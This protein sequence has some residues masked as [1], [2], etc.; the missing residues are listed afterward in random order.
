MLKLVHCCKEAKITQAA[1]AKGLGYS[2]ALISRI[3]RTGELPVDREGFLLSLTGFVDKTPAMEDYLANTLKRA[4]I[5]AL[6]EAEETDDMGEAGQAPGSFLEG[7]F[8]AA[9]TRITFAAG[10]AVIG[11]PQLEQ[12]LCLARLSTFLLKTL[13]DQPMGMDTLGEIEVEVRR[14]L[15]GL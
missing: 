4:D 8:D 3:F 9:E 1:L 12:V 6:L 11:G 14:M 13:R 2:Q 15:G 10:E 5:T 7:Q